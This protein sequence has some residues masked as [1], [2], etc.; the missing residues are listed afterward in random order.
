MVYVKHWEVEENCL[1]SLYKQR[2]V[3][4]KAFVPFANGFLFLGASFRGGGVLP[5]SLGKHL[6]IDF[7]LT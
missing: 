2:F 5:C 6:K 3:L 7:K 4:L 1:F